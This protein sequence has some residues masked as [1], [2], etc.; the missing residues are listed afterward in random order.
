MFHLIGL[1]QASALR[2]NIILVYLPNLLGFARGGAAGRKAE[3]VFRGIPEERQKA[4][5]ALEGLR[6]QP[7]ALT[8]LRWLRE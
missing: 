1:P 7:A 2:S 8:L 5:R 3:D 4:E 6:G